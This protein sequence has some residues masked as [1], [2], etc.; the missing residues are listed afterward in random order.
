MAFLQRNPH[1]PPALQAGHNHS[2][3][4]YPDPKILS[5]D[6]ESIAVATELPPINTIYPHSLAHGYPP[7]QLHTAM[8]DRWILVKELLCPGKEDGDSLAGY[9]LCM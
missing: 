9:L 7:S 6:K 2:S 4:V 3:L 8:A 1:L 5:G